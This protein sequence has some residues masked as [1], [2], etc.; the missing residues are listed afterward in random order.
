MARTRL[1]I[2]V[3]KV[4]G[5]VTHGLDTYRQVV[6]DDLPAEAMNQNLDFMRSRLREARG[7]YERVAQRMVQIRY[8]GGM[9]LGVPILLALGIFIGVG[10]FSPTSLAF[11]FNLQSVV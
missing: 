9:M 6:I 2:I 4:Y 8:F 3:E 7:F 10:L 5:I 11:P 1:Q